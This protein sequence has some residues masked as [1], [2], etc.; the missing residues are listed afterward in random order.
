MIQ[1]SDWQMIMRLVMSVL[2]C[3]AIGLEREV[4]GRSAGLRTHILVGLS[5]C[6]LMIISIFVAQSFG[7]AHMFDPGRIAAGVVTGMGFLGAGT[8]IRYGESIKGLTTAA[9]LWAV[10]AVG[11]AVGAGFYL[12]AYV[13][14]ALILITL[15]ALS[16]VEKSISKGK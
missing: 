7:E 14:T 1:V 6:L 12:A 10:T 9:S 3:G 15:F 16:R 4:R 13:S 8:I 5:S 11:L 2:L